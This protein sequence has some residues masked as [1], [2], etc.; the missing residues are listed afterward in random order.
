MFNISTTSMETTYLFHTN[1]NKQCTDVE[2]KQ[3]IANNGSFAREMSGQSL[4]ELFL[5]WRHFSA[6]DISRRYEVQYRSAK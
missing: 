5:K 2:I 4:Q 6:S 1:K 3:F